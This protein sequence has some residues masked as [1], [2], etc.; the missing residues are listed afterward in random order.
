MKALHFT[1]FGGPEVLNY[2]DVATPAVPPNHALIRMHAIGLNFADIYRRRGN[3]HLVGSPPYI[4]GYEG[5]GTV[6]QVGPSAS[7]MLVHVGSRV[8]FADVPNANAEFVVAPLTHL[9]PLPDDVSFIT[10]AAILLQGL[11]AHYLTHDS[12]HLIAGQTALVHAAAGGVGLC[13]IQIIT[14]LGGRAIGLVSS[15]DKRAAVVSAGATDVWRYS[16]AWVACAQKQNVDVVYD[17]VGSTLDESI[18]ACR[19]G[20]HIVFYGMAGGD[21]KPVNPR[22]LM[23]QSKTLS[24]GDLWNVLTSAEQ[25]QQRA[26]TLFSWLRDGKLHVTIAKQFALA[27]GAAAHRYLE[28]R[29]AIGKVVM[30]P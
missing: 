8:A 15:D 6:E 3:Y 26:A 13:L 9:V 29:A 14:L 28:S 22:V 5:A 19:T 7:P 20:G 27:D 4:A 25:R 21:P 24:G 16:D 18:T 10:A 1:H 12:H 2:G 30:I 11:T 23:D 17:A